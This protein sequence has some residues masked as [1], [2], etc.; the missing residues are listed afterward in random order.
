MDIKACPK[1]GGKGILKTTYD[2]E[3]VVCEK[4]GAETVEE[5]GDYY[6]EGCMDGMYVIPKWN[7]G[8]VTHSF[9]IK[10]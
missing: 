7:R 10:H 4:C 6:D 3:Q 9:I 2:T 8:E 5:W 1:C